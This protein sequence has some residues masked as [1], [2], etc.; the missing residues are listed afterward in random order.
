[1]SLLGAPWS[2]QVELVEGCTR[3][4]SFCGLNGIRDAPASNY[5]YV[6]LDTAERTAHQVLDLCPGA[7]IEFAMHGEPLVHPR[8]MHI[9][10]L[11]RELLPRTQLQVTTNGATFRKSMAHQVE[12]VF[13]S[14]IDII[15]LDTYY[16]ERDE[17]RAAAAKLPSTITVKD[18]YD[19]LAPAGWSPW[20]NHHR[21]VRRM[22]V[23]LDDL[24]ARDK[25]HAARVI[26]NHAGS[27]PGRPVPPIPLAKTCTNPFREVSVTWDGSVN[28]CCMDWK[29]EYTA[30]NVNSSTLRDIWYGPELEAAR[31]MLQQKDRRFAPCARCDKGSGARS[32]LLPKY[33]APTAEQLATVARVTRE[34]VGDDWVCTGQPSPR[35]LPVIA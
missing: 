3:L 16:P 13:A 18:F 27:N 1:M 8:A 9:F 5:R 4:C 12:R 31:S 7:R 20:A 23:L 29:G 24:E 17:L 34:A 19:D 30:G 22:I 14:G 33:P 6:S 26:L 10:S 2:V 28:I 35:R 25:E 21:K 11:F 32:G 15:V